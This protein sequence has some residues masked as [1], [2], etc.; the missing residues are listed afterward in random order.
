MKLLAPLADQLRLLTGALDEGAGIDGGDFDDAG[1]DG[2]GILFALARVWSDARATVPSFCG[3]TISVLG[4]DTPFTFTVLEGG[5]SAA[6]IETSLFIPYPQA[7]P[8]PAPAVAITLYARVP[9]AFVDLSADLA[10]LSGQ[11]L[12]DFVRDQHLAPPDVSHTAVADDAAINQALGV[13]IGRGY[14]IGEAEEFLDADGAA[15]MD[16]RFVAQAVLDSLADDP[17]VFQTPDV[18][19]VEDA[20]GAA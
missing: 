10:W 6:E 12:A 8:D 11:D 17:D 2:A 16:R 1:K 9:G 5:A 13:L 18:D 14:T 15:G 4:R 19:D 20:G 3:L 7:Q